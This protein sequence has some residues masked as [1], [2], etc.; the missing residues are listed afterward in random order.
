LSQCNHPGCD[1]YQ[2]WT[3]NSWSKNSYW[4]LGYGGQKIAWNHTNDKIMVAF[5]TSENWHPEAARLYELW[6]KEK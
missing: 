3:D 4:A 1:S 2:I 5:S 6:S